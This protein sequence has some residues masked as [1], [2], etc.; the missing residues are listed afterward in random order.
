ME[1]KKIYNLIIL[2]ESGSMESIKNVIVSG[3]N[4]VIQNVKNSGKEFPN[5]DQFV[6]FISFNSVGVKKIC[7]KSEIKKMSVIDEKNYSPNAATPLFD[8]MGNSITELKYFLQDKNNYNVLVTILTDGLE[9]A[10]KEF[11]GSQ[12]KKLIEELKENNWTFT[13][14]GTDHDVDKIADSISINNKLVFNKTKRGV[15]DMY[16]KESESRIRYMKRVSE[17][18]DESYDYFENKIG[19]DKNNSSEKKNNKQR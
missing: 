17:D 10:S 8:A 5:L 12:I 2:D 16:L 19:N 3:L 18:L 11:S 9:N 13:Y 1:S 15:A 4:E 14:I 6:T 7:D